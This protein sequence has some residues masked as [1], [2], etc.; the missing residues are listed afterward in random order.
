MTAREPLSPRNSEVARLRGLTR[1]RRARHEAGRFIVE[2]VKLVTEVMASDLVVFEVY[3]AADWDPPSQFLADLEADDVELTMMTTRAIERISSTTSPQ[4][5]VA[6]VRLAS[7]DW[8]AIPAGASMLVAV[9]LNDPGNV[10]TLAR[11]AVAAGFGAVVCLGDTADAFGPKTIRASAGAL[12]RVPVIVERGVEAGLTKIAEHGVTRY[13]TRMQNATPCDQ[14]DLTGPVALV[15][16]SEAHGLGETHDANIDEWL[17]V[18]MPG[19]TESLN[20]AMAGTILT[21][22]VGRQRRGK[23]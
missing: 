12:F 22:E 7:A 16:G 2:G 5:V 6:E 20:V 23:V 17:S 21:Y 18:P 1:E 8:E 15:L 19:E 3:A 4:P 11:S 9:D 13:G 10:G 14:A